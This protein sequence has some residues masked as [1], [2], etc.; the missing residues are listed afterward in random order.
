VEGREKRVRGRTSGS[1]WLFF[2]C[3]YGFRRRSAKKRG[4]DLRDERR[5]ERRVELCAAALSSTCNSPRLVCIGGRPKGGEV[6]EEEERNF[7][8]SRHIAR[9]TAYWARSRGR[10]EKTSA[11]VLAS[12]VKRANKDA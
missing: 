12:A 3:L 11:P 1:V 5:G 6:G 7:P 8:R 2:L 4:K 10:K 9:Q